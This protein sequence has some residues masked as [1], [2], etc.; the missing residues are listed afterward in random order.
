MRS[1][2]RSHLTRVRNIEGRSPRPMPS[3]HDRLSGVRRTTSGHASPESHPTDQRPQL[4][5]PRPWPSSRSTPGRATPRPHPSHEATR[6]G[7]P[8]RGLLVRLPTADDPTPPTPG[9]RPAPTQTVLPRGRRGWPL[10]GVIPPLEHVVRASGRHR[11][12]TA[13]C[14]VGRCS[15]GR[16]H[17]IVAASWLLRPG[18]VRRTRNGRGEI[19]GRAGPEGLQPTKKTVIS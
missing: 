12:K 17:R 3:C 9:R 5:P 10:G 14:C 11:C 18:V 2:C 8:I 13:R 4:P 6:R 15:S 1:V 7:K 19:C 16:T